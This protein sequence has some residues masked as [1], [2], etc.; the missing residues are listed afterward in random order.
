MAS[1]LQAAVVVS[2]VSQTQKSQT[3]YLSWLWI[4]VGTNNVRVSHSK[5][6]REKQ[7]QRETNIASLT[8]TP[9]SNKDS[10][11]IIHLSI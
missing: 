1:G 8:H 5:G 9:N 11:S 6:S 3:L 4:F 7:W 10:G 2:P